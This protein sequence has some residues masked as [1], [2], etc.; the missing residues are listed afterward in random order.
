MS[1]RSREFLNFKRVDNP[2]GS[3]PTG[4]RTK[5]VDFDDVGLAPRTLVAYSCSIERE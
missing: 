3:A 2:G 1:I 5:K 4:T